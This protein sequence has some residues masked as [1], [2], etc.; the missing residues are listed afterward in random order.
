M[1]TQSFKLQLYNF[2][3]ITSFKKHKIEIFAFK[4]KHVYI[5]VKTFTSSPC[6]YV[7][8]LLTQTYKMEIEETWDEKAEFPSFTASTSPI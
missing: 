3:T 7:P 6:M 1:K 2:S 4:Q 8:L 5:Q